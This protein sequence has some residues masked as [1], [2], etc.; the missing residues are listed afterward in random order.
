MYCSKGRSTELHLIHLITIYVCVC[1]I[2]AWWE[3]SSPI[4]CKS[5]WRWELTEQGGASSLRIYESCMLYVDGLWCLVE[6]IRCTLAL[7]SEDVEESFW[8]KV[9]GTIACCALSCW[10]C[11]SHLVSWA[12]D[13]F[14][15]HIGMTMTIDDKRYKSRVAAEM[16]RWKKLSQGARTTPKPSTSP[17]RNPDLQPHA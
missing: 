2:G 12:P 17:R 1:A 15:P 7:R 16:V 11:N 4:L 14:D 13:V 3:V 8:S 9:L 10:I 5:V 6:P